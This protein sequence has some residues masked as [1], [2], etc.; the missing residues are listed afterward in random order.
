MNH[1]IS[2]TYNFGL[3]GLEVGAVELPAQEGIVDPFQLFRNL[4]QRVL[5]LL[6]QTLDIQVFK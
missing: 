5:I 1:R 2:E 4:P 3:Q 6:L